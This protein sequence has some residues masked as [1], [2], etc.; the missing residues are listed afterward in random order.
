MSTSC[1]TRSESRS[2]TPRGRPTLLDS[3]SSP[4]RGL[5]NLRFFVGS[6]TCSLS[7]RSF[8]HEECS[9]CEDS[10]HLILDGG[11]CVMSE[12]CVCWTKFCC[13]FTR[14]Q[15][16]DFCEQNGTQSEEFHDDFRNPFSQ[17]YVF[18]TPTMFCLHSDNVF[19]TP[20][21]FFATQTCFLQPH[22]LFC[23]HKIV[24]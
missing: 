11:F 9:S 2:L 16:K 18:C 19:R 7:A 23:T 10:N 5:C 3:T 6:V 4:K 12:C 22:N 17:F 24:L 1:G 15:M 8:F 21:M 20:K 14:C 13:C